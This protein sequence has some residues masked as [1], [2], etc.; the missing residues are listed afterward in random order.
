MYIR[1]CTQTYTRVIASNFTTDG[2]A[3]L[4]FVNP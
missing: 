4:G 2:A 1:V 3:G